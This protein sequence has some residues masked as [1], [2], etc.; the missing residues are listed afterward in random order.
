MSAEVCV[1]RND[2]SRPQQPA[3]HCNCATHIDT[4]TQT[5][6]EALGM[7]TVVH[8]ATNTILAG[9]HV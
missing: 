1:L 5:E 6:N 4:S 9:T 8:V 2:L 3:W 7:F